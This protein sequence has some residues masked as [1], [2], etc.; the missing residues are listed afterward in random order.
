MYEVGIRAQPLRPEDRRPVSE[1]EEMA[2]GKIYES[3]F[4]PERP[5]DYGEQVRVAN[6]IAAQKLFEGAEVSYVGADANSVVVQYSRPRTA[7]AP[8]PAIPLTYIIAL[9]LVAITA[10]AIAYIAVRLTPVANAVLETVNPLTLN[11]AV[12]GAGLLL[13]AGAIWFL[14][15]MFRPEVEA[16][17]YGIRGKLEERRRAKAERFRYF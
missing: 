17:R 12:L 16:A 7:G 3:E 14:G 10:V 15:R 4:R 1:D 5:L 2:P 9:V 13:V 11:V 6:A 8:L